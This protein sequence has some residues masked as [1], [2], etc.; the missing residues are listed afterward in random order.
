MR[1]ARLLFSPVALPLAGANLKLYLKDGEFHLVREYRSKATVCDFY[2]LELSDWEEIPVAL[3]DLKRTEIEAAEIKAVPSSKPKK[4]PTKKELIREARAE[5]RKIPQDPGLYRLENDQLRVFKETSQ[6][7]T[8]I[9][10]ASSQDPFSAPT[11]STA[12]P[13]LRSKASTQPISSMRTAPN[14]SSSWPE[15]K[16][17]PFSN[18]RRKRRS[19]RGKDHASSG[20]QRNSGGSLKV[21][22]FQKELSDSG[23][24]KIWPQ[25]PSK[26][27][28]TRSSNSLPRK[29]NHAL[30]LPHPITNRVSETRY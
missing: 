20:L 8:T 29:M 13:R 9:K 11:C 7:S 19:H 3:I 17:L 15:W 1:N 27:P 30:G 28:I 21:E 6:S 5:I 25:E 12:N 22:I 18:S 26:R 16:A 4:F 14:S 2:S 24:F 10:D 23:L